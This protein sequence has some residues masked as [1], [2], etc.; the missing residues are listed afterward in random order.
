M[1]DTLLRFD[2]VRE[3]NEKIFTLDTEDSR[4]RNELRLD[5]MPQVVDKPFKHILPW[6]RKNDNDDSPD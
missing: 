5:A 4:L 2:S 1:E 6:G 3:K